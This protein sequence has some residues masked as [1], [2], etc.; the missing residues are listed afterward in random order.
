MIQIFR[1]SPLGEALSH[2]VRAP[3]TPEW[4]IIYYLKR[5][6][7]ATKDQ[8]VTNSG[9]SLAEVSAALTKL[10]HRRSPIV[11]EETGAAEA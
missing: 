11:I 9:L 2:S 8:I 5:Q 7:H 10:R 4:K 6:G 3:Q 1:L